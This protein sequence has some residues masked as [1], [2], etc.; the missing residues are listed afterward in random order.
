M[1]ST[2]F[3]RSSRIGLWLGIAANVLATLIAAGLAA[4]MAPPFG[5]SAA[6]A[7]VVCH[8]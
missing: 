3:D 5:H 2:R 7:T 1:S 6:A 4:R 8:A